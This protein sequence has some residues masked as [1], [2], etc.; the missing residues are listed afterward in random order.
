MRAVAESAD[1]AALMSLYEA[2][3]DELYGFALNRLKDRGLAED[4]VQ[5]VFIRVW[6]RAA[7]YDTAR[8]DFRAWLYGIARNTLIDLERRRR[9]RPE[10][11]REVDTAAPSD[12]IEDAVARWQVRAAL[13]RL[14]PAHRAVIR[15]VRIEGL[16]VREAAERT[17]L[18]EGTVKSRLWYALKALRLSLEEGG[19][20]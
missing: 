16:T 17:G 19:L 1:D 6:S 8:G 13:D 15:L 20:L 18:P 7:T 10:L 4:F 9:V 14:S 12:E 5:D 2:H 3:A 11:V